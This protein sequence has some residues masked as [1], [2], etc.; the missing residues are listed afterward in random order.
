MCVLLFDMIPSCGGQNS[1]KIIVVVVVVVVVLLFAVCF[2]MCWL[3]VDM[4]QVFGVLVRL[5]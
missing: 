5:P 4:A 1:L 2:P 3:L